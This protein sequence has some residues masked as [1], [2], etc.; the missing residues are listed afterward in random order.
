MCES[1]DFE[2]R[3]SALIMKLALFYKNDGI[4]DKDCTRLD[5]GNPG[6]GGTPFMVYLIAYLLQVR[7]NGIDVLLLTSF[8]PLIPKGIKTGHA[9]CL[10]QAYAMCEEQGYDYLIIK[11]MDSYEA[12]DQRVFLEGGRTK[13][14]IWCHNFV[15]NGM[16]QFY[17]NSK[18]VCRII[19]VGREQMDLYRDHKAFNKSDYIYNAI[20]VPQLTNQTFQVQPFAQRKNIVTY[21][22]AVIQGKGFHI[23]AKAW[24]DVLKEVP[25]AELYVIGSGRLYNHGAKLGE[26]NLAEEKYEKSFMK[27]LTKDG[28]LLPGVHL[29][30]MLGKEKMEI[31][32]K[33][34]VGVPNPSGLT[35]TFCLCGVEMQMA[36]AR[37]AA[38]RC[39]GYL[40]T[41]R[42]GTFFKKR[43]QLSD[44]IIKELK[45]KDND[46]D[47]AIEFLNQKFSQDVI[48]GDWERL[49]KECI[50]QGTHLHDI[51]PLSNSSFQLK[52]LK[53][54]LRVL[55][56]RFPALY[57]LPTVD[58]MVSFW[59]K[60][61]YKLF[62]FRNGFNF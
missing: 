36:G 6:I 8:E 58:S 11:H 1:R 25:D 2:A 52:W 53:D 60:I 16:L 28:K 22:G 32:G 20:D 5:K 54:R 27:Y 17:S 29:V 56:S 62:K 3:F 43:S 13:L 31:L 4:R 59:E 48:V 49:L 57:A 35:E 46:Y 38:Y 45:G 14:L 41:V 33:T 42:N 26:W 24:K 55:K 15:D 10:S 23:L 7:D 30:G 19:A 21:L 34:K 44:C 18:T 12:E 51:Y 9:D 50:P 37:I 61:D 47:S 40:D 39:A